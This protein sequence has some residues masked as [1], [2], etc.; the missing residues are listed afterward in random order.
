MLSPTLSSS[1]SNCRR[2][3][4]NRCR[5][6]LTAFAFLGLVGVARLLSTLLRVLLG[7]LPL[8]ASF[9]RGGLLRSSFVSILGR[10]CGR[11]LRRVIFAFSFLT[12]VI[13]T[14]F[15]TIYHSKS[16]TST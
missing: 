14:P 13:P 15:A 4:F 12:L 16:S 9:F 11:R 2:V 8:R 10:R 5:G 3:R 1:Y 6:H 7:V